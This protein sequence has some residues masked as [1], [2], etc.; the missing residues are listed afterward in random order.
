MTRRRLVQGVLLAVLALPSAATAASVLDV[1]AVP[2]LDE[3]GRASYRTWLGSNLP[4]AFAVAPDGK[5]GWVSGW[6]GSTAEAVRTRALD[7]C[8]AKG[9][10]GC[11]LYAENLSV[12]WPGQ[13][14]TPPPVKGPLEATLNYAFVPDD[15]Y[16][17]RG[18]QAARGVYVW[19]HGYGGTAAPDPRGAQPQPHVRAFNN[20]GYDIVRFDRE[21]NADER[22]RAAGWLRDGLAELRRRGYRSVVVGGQSR[23]AWNALQMLGTPGLADAVVAISPAAHGQGSS[24]N[25]TAQYDDL[26]AVLSD[27]P[28]GRT[29]VVVA[30]F[31]QDPFDGD[32]ERRAALF[33]ARAQ[34]MGA[35]LLIDRP[36]GL[37]GHYAGGT[38]EFGQRF[39]PCIARFVLDGG[40]PSCGP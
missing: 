25:L 12:V 34:A 29:R 32:A 9:A 33:R 6:A 27:A 2:Y 23:G 30:Q 14:S 38:S 31:A 39:G 5:L 8:S 1:T 24:T 13:Q 21:P 36:D 37:T 17:W 15:R 11:A 40:P 16:L 35:L 22:Q 19:A 3:A 18:P 26:R 4:R 7:L 20:A 10:A 28:P